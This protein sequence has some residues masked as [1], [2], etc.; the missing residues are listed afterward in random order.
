MRYRSTRGKITNSLNSA[1][2]VIQGLA[3]DGGLLVPVEFPKVDLPLDQLPGMTYQEMAQMVLGWFFDDFSKEQ[4]HQIVTTAYGNQWDTHQIAP[5]TAQHSGNY[6][7]ELFHGPTLA[8]KDVALQVLPRLMTHA[9]TIEKINHEIIILTA[10]SGDTGTASMRGFSDQKG[11]HVIVF[12]P[13]GGV[14]PVQL[15]QM[16][17]QEGANLTAVAIQGNFDDAQTAVKK[18]FN[19]EQF[20]HHLQANHYQFSSANSMNIGRLIPQIVY[21]LSAY[22]QLVQRGAIQNGDAVN[23]T[24]PTGNFGDLLAAY[25]AKELGLPINKLIC[26]SDENNV[27]TDFFRFGTYDRQRQFYLTNSPAMD[28]LVS[29]NLERLLFDVYHGD[30]EAIQS[31]MTKLDRDGH[32]SISPAA[33]KR[34]DQT[35]T[36]GAADQEQ[37]IQEI[38]RIFTADG[39][40]IDPHTA[41]ASHVTHQYQK[42]SKDATPTVIISTASPYKFPETVYEAI[43]G[44]QPSSTGLSAIQDLH[45]RLQQPLGPNV[46]ALF[47]QL[48]RP[49]KVIE[50]SEME[51]TINQVLNLQ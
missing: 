28:I 25:Y 4:L 47:D 26:A 2:A 7:L 18:I 40:V 41:V 35:F 20:N 45:Q 33:K 30:H 16:L 12:Y 5:L 42:Q 36:A 13:H 48:A 43:T 27:L 23:F 38:H 21:Y 3:S 19:D 1:E 9:V 22:G 46:Q 34:L 44:K 24:V 6:Y 14:S 31:L 37:V 51:A 29:S 10:T 49:E 17:G 39:Y 32:Y 50:P 8:F 11:T 15:Q